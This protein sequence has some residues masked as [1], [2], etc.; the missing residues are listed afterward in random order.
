MGLFNFLFGGPPRNGAGP[1]LARTAEMFHAGLSQT[2]IA[3]GCLSEDYSAISMDA[4]TAAIIAL[5]VC[6]F[7]Y[8]GV[9]AP[10]SPTNHK[11]VLA[12]IGGSL[13]AARDSPAE[14]R[15]A[16]FAAIVTLGAADAQWTAIGGGAPIAGLKLH[17]NF[18]S[19][20]TAAAGRAA[21]KVE[22]KLGIAVSPSTQ[23]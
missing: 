9:A 1:C 16:A 15:R 10:V 18:R 11:A 23:F 20:V 4:L 13:E 12:M 5:S 19:A 21:I 14:G 17:Q 22:K 2:L 6:R 8:R 7:D 3:E